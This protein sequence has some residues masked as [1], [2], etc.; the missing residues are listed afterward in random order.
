MMWVWWWDFT[1]S[2]QDERNGEGSDEFDMKR[3]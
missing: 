1:I 3:T 2:V